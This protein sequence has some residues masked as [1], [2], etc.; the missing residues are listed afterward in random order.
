MAVGFKKF[1]L[2]NNLEFIGEI[3]CMYTVRKVT[4]YTWSLRLMPT[5]LISYLALNYNLIS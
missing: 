2:C 1:S 3:V 5:N 4:Y